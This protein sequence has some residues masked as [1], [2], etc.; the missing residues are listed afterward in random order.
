MV[1]YGSLR[2]ALQTDPRRLAASFALAQSGWILLGIFSFSLTGLQGALVE[3]LGLAVSLAAFFTVLAM[4]LR[5]RE[6]RELEH[7]GGW[8]A[9]TPRLALAFLFTLLSLAAFPGLGD[10]SG[11]FLILIS[12]YKTSAWIGLTAAG[13]FVFSAWSLVHLFEKIFL[14]PVAVKPG[15][16][17]EDLTLREA[18]LLAPFLAASIWIGVSP[19]SLLQPMEKTVQLNVLQRLNALPVMMDFAVEQRRL[20]DQKK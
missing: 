2:A 16:K 1:V 4:I 3:M 14:G 20:Q 13:T 12:V 19:N 18:L 7:F 5:R 10:F 6:S 17:I 11:I 8:M 15:A 9:K